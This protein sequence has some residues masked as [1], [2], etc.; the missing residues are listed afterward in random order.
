M[1]ATAKHMAPADAPAHTQ[2]LGEESS[3]WFKLTP[4]LKIG[5]DNPMRILMQMAE[6]YGAVIPINHGQPAHRAADR[7]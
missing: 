5:L 1:T 4:L 7:A 2:G 3:I 6:R